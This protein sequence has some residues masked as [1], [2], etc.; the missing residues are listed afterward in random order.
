[1]P[2]TSAVVVFMTSLMALPMSYILNSISHLKNPPLI[3][4]SGLIALCVI[5]LIPWVILRQRLLKV[6][7]IYYALGLL[8]YSSVMSLVI[9]L[10]NDGLI[11][12]F[13]GAY[14]RE[15]E[16][17]LKT[18]HGTMI[19]Y[20]DG[21]AHY[22]MYLMMLAAFSWNQTFHDVGLYWVGSYG[23]SKL[24]LIVAAM[25]GKDGIRWPF[26][27]TVPYVIICA[28]MCANFI[29]EKF[30]EIQHIQN[31]SNLHEDLQ[32]NKT[33]TV[34]IWRRPRDLLF[35]IYFIF[36]IIMTII[37]FS[38][39]MQS[40]FYLSNLYRDSVEPY[41]TDPSLY[42]KSQLMVQVFYFIPYYLLS[43]YALV[44]PGK[45]WYLPSCIIFAG[46]A[47]QAQFSLIGSSFHYRTPY[48]HRV[49]QTLFARSLFWFVNGLQFL[50]PQLMAYSCLS[51]PS[52]YLRRSSSPLST[53]ASQPT[54]AII[55]NGALDGHSVGSRRGSSTNSQGVGRMKYD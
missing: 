26:L 14:L 9:A 55:N 8:A 49:P 21:I 31:E 53:T 17:Y 6:N 54:R 25:I 11:A 19:S 44:Q 18:A 13:M 29:A 23:Y 16:P 15:G 7:P 10:E 52:Q 50:V 39:T 2:L 38:G 3:L 36:A 22:A 27:L 40:N 28:L 48:L 51:E 41:L 1:M 33:M 32:K 4:M 34:S 43:M 20:W 42:S 12:D 30:E 24:I 45:S 5:S 47:A 46:A 35:F 37:R